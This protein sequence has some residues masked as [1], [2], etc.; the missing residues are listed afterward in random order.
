MQETRLYT[1]HPAMSSVIIS[2]WT[3]YDTAPFSSTE[4]TRSSVHTA[5]LS[6]LGICPTPSEEMFNRRSPKPA[7]SSARA[8]H[9]QLPIMHLCSLTVYLRGNLASSHYGWQCVGLGQKRLYEVRDCPTYCSEPRV[10]VSQEGLRHTHIRSW[11]CA[12]LRNAGDSSMSQKADVET[13]CIV[14]SKFL[15]AQQLHSATLTLQA[16]SFASSPFNRTKSHAPGSHTS[17]RAWKRCSR[18]GH[19]Y[20][21][22]VNGRADGQDARLRS[23]SQRRER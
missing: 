2:A 11:S 15:Y 16:S 8:E 5:N 9:V 12:T 10:V 20:T 22:G 7:K 4:E 17:H 18:D 6:S 13:E 21:G 1:N 23:S 14:P 19:L 3:S